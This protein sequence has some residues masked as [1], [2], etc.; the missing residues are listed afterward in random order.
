MDAMNKIKDM[1][2]M[3][4]EEFAK[5]G[6]LTAQ[7]LDAIHKLV[8]TKEKLLRTEQIEGEMGGYSQDGGWT[9][10]G[11][12]SRTGYPMDG[13]PMRGNS[14]ETNSYG[15]DP[16]EQSMRKGRY[17]MDEGRSMMGDRLSDMMNDPSLSQ[18]ERNALK[19]AMDAMR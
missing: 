7:D 4:L 18:Q 8:I 12:Y 17:S 1:V 19:K 16:Y 2:C 13:Y 15:M 6:K 9:A 14:Y 10:R 5:K 11:H 3:E